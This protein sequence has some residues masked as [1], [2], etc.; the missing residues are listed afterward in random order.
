[1][2]GT[3]LLG[4]AVC[5]G[6]GCSKKPAAS[7]PAPG[8]PAAPVKLVPGQPIGSAGDKLVVPAQTF[9]R[10]KADDTKAAPGGLTSGTVV[11]SNPADGVAEAEFLRIIPAG[12]SEWEYEIRGAGKRPVQF[13][14]KKGAM[15]AKG[16]GTDRGVLFTADTTV[17]YDPGITWQNQDYE[18][19]NR[20]GEVIFTSPR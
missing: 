12:K 19:A 2:R 17:D 8:A 1:M 16:L 20:T 3:S 6:L 14:A 10:T 7:D 13:R 4:L 11:G 18:I 5:V 9:L 15:K